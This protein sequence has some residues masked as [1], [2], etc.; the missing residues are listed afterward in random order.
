MPAFKSVEY[1]SRSTACYREGD[2]DTV[3]ISVNN[4]DGDVARLRPGWRDVL[5]LQ[6]DNIDAI[7]QRL[8]RF[9]PTQARETL[10]FLEKHAGHDLKLLVH[11]S[12]G[13]SRSPAIAKFAAEKYGL[14]FPEEADYH[15]WT[16]YALGRVDQS[17]RQ[18]IV[19]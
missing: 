1:V 11:C 8:V 19:R 6:F 2:A 3:L 16:Y 12:E 5:V 17:M 4:S 18:G 10:D 13:R 9:G 14:P 7:H 15:E